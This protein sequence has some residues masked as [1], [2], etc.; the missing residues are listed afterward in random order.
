[1]IDY[2]LFVHKKSVWKRKVC[3]IF[4]K[5]NLKLK[6]KPKKLFFVGFFRWGFLGF[7]GWVL[8]CGFFNANPAHDS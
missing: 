2:Y 7:F 6:K 4:I 1:M 8:L 3:I 5:K